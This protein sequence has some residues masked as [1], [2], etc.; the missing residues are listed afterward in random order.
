MNTYMSIGKHDN[1]INVIAKVQENVKNRPF[2]N[3]ITLLLD[4]NY[5]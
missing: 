1:L 4:F 2:F 3:E 5:V